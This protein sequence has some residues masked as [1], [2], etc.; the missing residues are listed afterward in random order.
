MS[1]K[2]IELKDLT[3]GKQIFVKG[4]IESSQIITKLRGDELKEDQEYRKRHMLPPIL[5]PY[6]CI[7]LEHAEV[8]QQFGNKTESQYIRQQIL[9]TRELHNSLTCYNQSKKK[10]RVFIKNMPWARKFLLETKL[11]KELSMGTYVIVSLRVTG[12]DTVD[13]CRLE[14]IYVEEYGRLIPDEIHHIVVELEEIDKY[15]KNYEYF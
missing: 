3:V 12:E 5:K 10:P 6:T 7:W 1:E 15:G 8:I 13:S 2:T 9:N 4:Q 14:K 11:K